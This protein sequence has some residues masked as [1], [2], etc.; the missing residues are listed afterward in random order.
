M[1][2]LLV[3]LL[4]GADFL[5]PGSQQCLRVC[6]GLPPELSLLSEVANWQD[7]GALSGSAVASPWALAATSTDAWNPA[8]YPAGYASEEALTLAAS[9]VLLLAWA[10]A[11]FAYFSGRQWCVCRPRSCFGS[12]NIVQLG[13]VPAD[14]GAT[15]VVPSLSRCPHL[16]VLGGREPIMENSAKRTLPR[17]PTAGLAVGSGERLERWREPCRGWRWRRQLGRLAA[18]DR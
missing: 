4:V 5:R 8:W 11:A 7:Q 3:S 1:M 2:R 13:V 18:S 12:S 16:G 9:S 10:T 6:A 15:R 14:R 17:R